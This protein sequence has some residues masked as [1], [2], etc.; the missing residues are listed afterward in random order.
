MTYSPFGYSL[1]QLSVTGYAATTASWNGTVSLN[2]TVQNQGASSLIEPLNL[3]PSQTDPNTGAV[4][5][6]TSTADAPATTVEVFAS[7]KPHAKSASIEIGTIAIPSV[8]QNSLY[9]TV[10]TIALPSRPKGLPGNGGKVYLTL[11]VDNDQT[12]TQ[13][14]QV[15]NVYRVPKPV[16]ITNPLPDLQVAA[17]DIPSPLQPGDVITP[18]IRI[19]NLG[20][21][22]PA[23]Q[24][25]GP[26][27][28]ELVA[29]QNTTF[30]PGDSVVGSFQ[31]ASLPGVSAIPTQDPDL[32]VN[33]NVIPPS[34]EFTTTLSPIK[35]PTTPGTYFLG[36]VIDP[37]N[38]I[39]ETY[40]PSAALRNVVTV[41][42]TDPLLPPSSLIVNTGGVVPLFP[43]LPSSVL[44][45]PA[46]TAPPTVQF[47]PPNYLT[48]TL[49]NAIQLKS[50]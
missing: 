26:V 19:V 2:V 50:K 49:L 45:P 29:S 4:T 10:A 48:G 41:G 39:K 11:V 40:A 1:P 15:L 33:G 31:I 20:S 28:V 9:N 34:N 24:N 30:G 6:T 35:L 8:P 38:K 3:A 5:P 22:D 17:L 21:A 47:P 37:T 16:R 46:S 36:I 13:S 25:Q 23:A 7:A 12:I 18:T 42:P 44:T 43:A 14:S 27:T 32:S